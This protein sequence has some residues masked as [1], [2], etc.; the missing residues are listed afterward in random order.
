MRTVLAS[1]LLLLGL[2]ACG[3][4]IVITMPGGGP[5]R[6]RLP[7]G[8]VQLYSPAPHAF[9]YSLPGEPVRSGKVSE[10]YELRD[11]D[12]GGSDC[13]N[14][15]ARTEIVQ[16]PGS[17]V[18]RLN[19]DI[20][21]GWS[22]FNATV[23]TVTRDQALGT[24]FGQ[25]KLEGEQPAIFRLLQVPVG[26]NGFAGCDRRYCT[27]TGS[28]ADD[29]V[30]ELAEMNDALGW[31]AAQNNGRVCRLFSL[32]Q[33][34]GRWVDLV[35]N[36]NFGTD[37]YGYLRVWVNGQLKCDYQGQLVSTARAATKVSGP[38]VRRGIFNSYMGRWEKAFGGMPKPTLVVFYDE[39][40]TGVSRSSVDPGSGGQG[41]VD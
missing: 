19:Q 10:R 14:F 1:L 24:V 31:G 4:V 38:S 11:G 28:S 23:G 18:A 9:R 27:G 26:D 17:I 3:Q 33:N 5:L 32:E 6:A 29:V 20:W 15:R 21:Y 7:D 22:F 39:F 8:Y 2:V 12:C 30:V 36:T 40:R 13:G 16:E 37:G 25:W 35:V 34:R 41:A